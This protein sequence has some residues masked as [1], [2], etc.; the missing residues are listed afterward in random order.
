MVS[1]RAIVEGRYRMGSVH[2]D[3]YCEPALIGAWP[4]AVRI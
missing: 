4:S 2:R 1:A 3:A